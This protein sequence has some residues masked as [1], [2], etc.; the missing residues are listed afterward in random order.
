MLMLF[1]RELGLTELRPEVNTLGCGECR[2]AYRKALVD[3]L[4]RID[5]ADLCEDCRRRV[6]RSPL[7]VLDCKIP[8]C[9][10]QTEDAPR[11]RDHVCGACSDHF[12]SVLAVLDRQEIGYAVNPRLVRGLDYYMRTTFE[13]VSGD[14]G[15]Q[16]SVAGGGRYD[17]LVRQLGGPDVPGIGF[18]CGMERLA[19]LL[20][21]KEEGPGRT[22]RPDFYFA[23]LDPSASAEA[24]HAAQVLREEHL[25]G[26]LSYCSGS[27]KSRLRQASHSNAEYC[28]ILGENELADRKVIIKHM[29]S[30]E[31]ALISLATLRDWAEIR[32]QHTLQKG[33]K[34]GTR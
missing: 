19:L 9:R 30:G 33:R 31:Q 8:S 13:I 28:L 23:V 22:G 17:G 25:V 14:I 11:I 2:P 21:E 10:E 24:L 26:E 34:G 7:R 29:D 15:A 4:R 32:Y 5:P 20:S 12:R 18:A 6:E 3:F 16:G 27:L 1:L